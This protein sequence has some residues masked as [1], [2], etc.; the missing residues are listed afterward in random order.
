MTAALLPSV[1]AVL[2]DPALPAWER[3]EWH[4]LKSRQQAL[5]DL[6]QRRDEFHWLNGCRI[7]YRTLAR[8]YLDRCR[9]Q[10]QWIADLKANDEGD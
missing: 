1:E 6:R 4:T 7:G 9:W 10:R 5:L 8:M 2:T 3:R